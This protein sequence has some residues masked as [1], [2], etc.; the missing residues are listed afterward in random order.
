MRFSALQLCSVQQSPAAVAA[1]Q[2][3]VILMNTL[4]LCRVTS[5]PMWTARCG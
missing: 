4:I 2:I 3:A 5:L 1:L